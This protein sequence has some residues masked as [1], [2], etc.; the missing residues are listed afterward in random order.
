MTMT[1]GKPLFILFGSAWLCVGCGSGSSVISDKDDFTAPRLEDNASE[2]LFD[3]SRL[4]QVD[5]QMPA[6]DFTTLRNEARTLDTALNECP[7]STFE[8]T[9]LTATVT[10]DGERLD[11]V[12]IRK[13]GFLGSITR[14]RPSF[15]LNFDTH[16]A[17]R[18][19]K[20]MKRMTLNNDRQ[21]PSHT[22]QCMAYDLFRAAGLVAPRCNL[23]HVT[24]NGE[25]MGI[26]SNVESIKKPFLKRNYGDDDGN[27]YEAQVADFGT[28]LNDKFE[29]KTNKKTPDR[30]DLSAISDALAMDDANMPSALA[31]LIDID[32]FINF[33]ALETLIGHWDSA[34]GNTNN[35]YIY[36]NPSDK[37]FHFIPWGTDAAF[38]GTNIFKPN[39]G[40]LY[41]NNRLASRLYA[42]E[43]FRQQYHDRIHALLGSVW[44]EN[45][46]L[47][48]VERTRL[49]TGAPDSAYS[50]MR[51]F[52]SGNADSA[53]KSQRQ[54][55]TSALAGTEPTQKEYVLPDVALDCDKP[56]SY[57]QL[58]AN[59]AS[60]ALSDTGTFSFT[61]REGTQV[62]ANMMI[63]T[64]GPTGVDSLVY[65]SNDASLPGVIELTL[66]GV[67]VAAAYKPYVLQLFIEKP[68]YTIGEHS[69]HGF[70]TNMMLFEVTST[71]PLV[72]T[73][74]GLGN[75]GS[76]TLEAA[77]TG[78]ASSSI[79]GSINA[80]LGLTPVA[81]N[82]N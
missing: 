50:S 74:I 37:L 34:T 73:P 56:A 8:Y 82:A 36:R 10:I 41:K 49:L 46:L 23:A 7:S 9:D 69:L 44:N 26:Y 57:S 15:K 12:D 55:L 81:N 71:T 16:V 2:D 70:A 39:S 54:L 4:I 63:A 76:I 80:Q 42:I 60:G 45:T 13:K 27:L 18:R 51:Q 75:T 38:T 77:G 58:S 5:I 43:G 62:T 79:K 32:E 35:Y 64:W 72:L 33:W 67:D 65:K 25:D 59:F 14:S 22:H 40:P 31:K 19:F 61:N 28:H 20:T 24:V 53:V 68:D 29:L 30:S 3:K 78:S 47:A 21:D 66:I 52:I 6:K 1:L 17:G 48:E 11:N